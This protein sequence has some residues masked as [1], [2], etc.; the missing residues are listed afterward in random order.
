[1]LSNLD[2]FPIL[3]L[4]FPFH[5]H[6]AHAMHCVPP[7]TLVETLKTIAKISQMGC[8]FSEI[9]TSNC[10]ICPPIKQTEKKHC[11]LGNF[12]CLGLRVIPKLQIVVGNVA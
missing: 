2:I 11:F 5:K 4:D 10:S 6:R 3:L 7:G 8:F 12:V 1:M 9:A